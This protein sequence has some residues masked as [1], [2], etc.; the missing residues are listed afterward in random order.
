M[1]PLDLLPYRPAPRF[2]REPDVNAY[3]ELHNLVAAAASTD[4]FSRADLD[5]IGRQR[6]VDLSIDFVGERLQLYQT[7]LDARLANSDL[8]REDRRVLTHVAHAL[9][10]SPADLRPAHERAFGKAVTSAISDDCLD[11]AERLLLY[12]LQHLLGLDPEIADGAYGVIAR[13]RL[14]RTVARVLCD[15]KLSPEEADEVAR[16]QSDLSL[17]LPPRIQA[18]LDGAA[19]RWAELNAALDPVHVHAP[20]TSGETAYFTADGATWTNVDLANYR[21]VFDASDYREQVAAGQTRSIR[22]PDVALEGA[23]MRGRVTV[24][25]RRLALQADGRGVQRINLSS[26]TA[27]QLFSNGVTARTGGGWHV[28]FEL[29]AQS[30]RFHT[31][32][33][34]LLSP[35]VVS[36]REEVTSEPAPRPQGAPQVPKPPERGARWR[37]VEHDEVWAVNPHPALGADSNLHILGHLEHGGWTESG[38]VRFSQEHVVL[39]G[40]SRRTVRL[41]MV[42]TAVRRGR[43]VWMPLGLAQGWLIEFRDEGDAETFAETIRSRDA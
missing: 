31:V 3:I 38:R 27:V 29:G 42:A 30:E 1:G 16:V 22:M 28:F 26:L 37:K 20:L 23:R 33:Y 41:S 18:M 10:L 15:G 19:A 4:E 21:K 32:L 14:L 9:A 7:L 11:V 5:R 6:G 39:D 8:D 35:D 36:P 40:S 17:R 13:E 12:K 43:V 24:T 25:D 2:G 34:R